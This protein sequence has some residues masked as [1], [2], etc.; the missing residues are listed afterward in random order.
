ML[1]ADCIEVRVEMEEWADLGSTDVVVGVS[2]V[3]RNSSRE[4]HA[5]RFGSVVPVE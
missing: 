3:A 5:N 1:V 4:R 2:P